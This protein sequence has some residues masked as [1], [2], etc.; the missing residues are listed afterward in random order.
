MLQNEVSSAYANL[1]EIKEAFVEFSNKVPFYGQ[2][3]VCLDDANVQSVLSRLRKPVVTYGFNRQAKYR[4][5]NLNFDSG[6]PCFEVLND[7][8]SLGKFTLKIP[9]TH[10]VLNATAAIA[11]TNEE[12]IPIEIIRK[13]VASFEGVKRRFEY[14]GKTKSGAFVYDDYA[15]HPD[16]IKATLSAAKMMGY[17]RIVTVFQPHTYSRLHDLFD[18]FAGSFENSDIT[19]FAKIFSASREKDVYGISS[20]NLADAVKGAIYIPE[21]E[22]IEEFLKKH[23]TKDDMVIVMGAGDVTKISKDLIKS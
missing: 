22:E 12:N 4:I 9:G 13:A 11:L 17:K 6:L 23:V 8:V 21:F 16:E 18:D 5:E 2:I 15:H 20:Q 7:G 3:I 19:V 1:Q 10:N 14:L